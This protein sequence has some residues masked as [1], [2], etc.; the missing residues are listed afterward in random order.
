MSRVPN[1]IIIGPLEYQV[2]EVENLHIDAGGTYQDLNGHILSDMGEIRLNAALSPSRLR[3][4]LLHE[5]LHGILFIVDGKHHEK[6]IIQLSHGL[7]DTLRRNP[8]L[9]DALMEGVER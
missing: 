1:S 9:V 2:R 3:V 4:T 6:L 5:V 8:A 7:V